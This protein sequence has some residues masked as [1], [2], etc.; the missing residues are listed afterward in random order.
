ML[1]S[2]GRLVRSKYKDTKGKDH[3][4]TNTDAST[5][6]N[7]HTYTNTNTNINTSAMAVKHPAYKASF[8]LPMS[9]YSGLNIDFDNHMNHEYKDVDDYIIDSNSENYSPTDS[10][11]NDSTVTI[12]LKSVQN[13][14]A[15]SRLRSQ[16]LMSMD[17]ETEGE[18]NILTKRSAEDHSTF[19]QPTT[20]HL[21][22]DIKDLARASIAYMDTNHH[23][24]S[25]S[26][27]ASISSVP[28]RI[29]TL[30]FDSEEPSDLQNDD[31]I[32]A[33]YTDELGG[34]SFDCI[35]TA[36]LQ[37]LSTHS[38]E[39]SRVGSYQLSQAPTAATPAQ[40]P[41]VPAPTRVEFVK[42][43]DSGIAT[44]SELLDFTV[45][46]LF[47]QKRDISQASKSLVAQPAPNSSPPPLPS[48]PIPDSSGLLKSKFGTGRFSESLR[49]FFRSF[50]RNST[51]AN[52]QSFAC[53]EA[54]RFGTCISDP[55][56]LLSNQKC[57]R[58]M[59]SSHDSGFSC[60]S[61][62]LPR[63]HGSRITPGRFSTKFRSTFAK[64]YARVT[65][66]VKQTMGR[67]LKNQNQRRREWIRARR[68]VRQE[69]RMSE[70]SVNCTPGLQDGYAERRS[71]VW[72]PGEAFPGILTTLVSSRP[73]TPPE[74]MSQESLN[75]I[76]PVA[77]ETP[78]NNTRYA[79]PVGVES[80]SEK[81]MTIR[82]LATRF[83]NRIGR[84]NKS[85]RDNEDETNIN[86]NEGALRTSS[87]V[88]GYAAFFRQENSGEHHEPEN[89]S[90]TVVVSSSTSYHLGLMLVNDIIE[91]DTPA[92]VSSV[93]SFA[94]E[95]AMETVGSSENDHGAE[96][97]DHGTSD[98]IFAQENINQEDYTTSTSTNVTDD[99]ASFDFMSAH[100]SEEQ[101][102]NVQPSPNASGEICH[103]KDKNVEPEELNASL[104]GIAE[105]LDSND[106]N[107]SW[108][109]ADRDGQDTESM[110]H[111]VE[112]ASTHPGIESAR[113]TGSH[114]IITVG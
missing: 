4:D 45:S 75:K 14:R 39:S 40:P 58:S 98:S 49:S 88:Q 6:T 72:R 25:E 12:P 60:K 112:I 87:G 95:L 35:P 32:Y 23:Y 13:H 55:G 113:T 52:E 17:D 91:H 92:A 76:V 71:Q 11:S 9:C 28:D 67:Y 29:G 54:I 106:E 82:P 81:V 105:R 30:P 44:S 68:L 3:E 101:A 100:E 94:N 27:L 19:E 15:F 33:L 61:V 22:E 99:D 74:F 84:N 107:G 114:E 43:S 51:S 57:V 42:A 37:A 80:G 2:T 50:R 109:S 41:P 63:S 59:P 65:R 10:Q 83:F 86:N 78:Q 102:V 89:K 5:Y 103:E 20:D 93:I 104:A 64:P 111:A 7:P 8:S 18:T 38:S 26:L 24:D 108:S 36:S 53:D 110:I 47:S 48:L 69:R 73:C 66:R 97:A 46:E 56:P 96:D 70:F 31:F 90:A 79:L 85:E 34:L 21:D 77:A 16:A 62:A 1:R